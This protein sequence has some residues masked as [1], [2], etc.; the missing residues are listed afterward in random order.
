MFGSAGASPPIWAS[1]CIYC[2]VGGAK[3][4]EQFVRYQLRFWCPREL[5][6]T[7]LVLDLPS[8]LVFFS[9]TVVVAALVA[10]FGC[11]FVFAVAPVSPC[12]LQ[13]TVYFAVATWHQYFALRCI[14][15]FAGCDSVHERRVPHALHLGPASAHVHHRRKGGL[16]LTSTTDESCTR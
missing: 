3:R 15:L 14:L 9:C 8:A 4:R 2:T 7:T 10:L 1:D 11:C 16:S 5:P 12:L 6:K 13:C